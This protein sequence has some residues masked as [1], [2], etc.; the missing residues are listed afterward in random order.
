MRGVI[1]SG[2]VGSAVLLLT[3]SPAQAGT[4]RVGDALPTVTLSDWQGDSVLLAAPQAGVMIIDFWAS[5]C[6][7]CRA[8]LPEL[9]AIAQRYAAD[10][11]QV[12]A[13][14]VDKTPQAADAFLKAYVPAPAMTLLY[15]PGGRGLAHY[16]AQGMPALY[17]VDSGGVVRLVEFGF[18]AE[19][20]RMVETTV[21][22][23]LR[24]SHHP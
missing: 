19:K 20:L 5:W 21:G 15:D 18:T 2:L 8:A 7:P 3:W 13:V 24:R 6:E 16:G 4:V 11:L 17:V 10:G 22:T 9:N 12:I 23:L 14:S 1:L